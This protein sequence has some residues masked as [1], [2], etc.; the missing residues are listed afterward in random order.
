[1]DIREITPLLVSSNLRNFSRIG[2]KSTS[3]NRQHGIN[4]LNTE[5]TIIANRGRK[6]FSDFHVA[7]T[8]FAKKW[9]ADQESIGGVSDLFISEA[10]ELARK[11]TILEAM[12]CGVTAVVCKGRDS[13]SGKT[14]AVKFVR[15][16]VEGLS[17][18]IRI[19]DCL[20]EARLQ[21]LCKNSNIV[22]LIDFELGKTFA[23]YVMEFVPQ[24][25]LEKIVE[26][27]SNVEY[28]EQ[29][30]AR[31]IRDIASALAF[32]HL[33]GVVHCDV[34]LDNLL[35]DSDGTV[36]LCDFGVA[37]QMHYVN[38]SI[39][40]TVATPLIAAPEIY[41]SGY[42]RPA[43]DMWSL[44]VCLYILLCG[45]PPFGDHDIKKRIKQ[46]RYVFIDRDW[47]PV[48]IMARDLISRLLVLDVENR[49]TALQV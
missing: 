27:N 20:E 7:H 41:A 1:M 34:K 42:C 24:S 29:M 32:C 37:E 19:C 39:Q 23:I 14:V 3:E 36:K 48:S 33:K 12:A 43:S 38:G 5:R 45:Y 46:A 30:A 6:I 8:N 22:E 17:E 21:K 11:Y 35:V 44:G 16:R 10:P 25:L 9:A 18:Q 40:R 2:M 28:N 49:L 47:A 31:Y 4:L 26:H 15:I 13:D